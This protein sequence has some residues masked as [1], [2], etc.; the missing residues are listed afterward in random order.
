MAAFPV[1]TILP[2]VL[3]T[4][5]IKLIIHHLLLASHMANPFPMELRVLT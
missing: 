1:V 5:M 3:L 2:S 4:P